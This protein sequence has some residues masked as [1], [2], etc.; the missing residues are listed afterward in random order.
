MMSEQRPRWW[1]RVSVALGATIGVWTLVIAAAYLIDAT[2]RE[3]WTTPSAARAAFGVLV[4]AACG[5]LIFGAAAYRSTELRAGLL[6]GGSVSAF[7]I[8]LFAGG[9]LDLIGGLLG[10]PSLLGILA[11][12]FALVESPKWWLATAYCLVCLLVAIGVLWLCF[13]IGERLG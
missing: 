12:G 2:R 11:A 1:R 3:T 7:L 5:L 9:N 10:L 4:V 13:T 6:L 8:G